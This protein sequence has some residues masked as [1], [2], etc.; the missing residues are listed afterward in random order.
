MR[1]RSVR[2]DYSAATS[3]R[4]D[5][6]TSSEACSR[7]IPH[8]VSQHFPQFIVV[9]WCLCTCAGERAPAAMASFTFAVLRPR[10]TQMIMRTICSDLRLIVNRPATPMPGGS[11]S[12][13]LRVK[14]F[15]FP[16]RPSPPA[17]CHPGSGPQVRVPREGGDPVLLNK[18]HRQRE[19]SPQSHRIHPARSGDGQL[20]NRGATT[21]PAHSAVGRALP[22]HPPPLIL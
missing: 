22:L 12:Q 15:P 7:I 14:K 21:L 8:T 5:E 11:A 16:A 6:Q 18:N 2:R 13:S 4:C 17:T 3:I 9:E 10:H 20:Q 19:P 1:G